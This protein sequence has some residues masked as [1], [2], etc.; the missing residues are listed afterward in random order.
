MKKIQWD[1][2]GK[3]YLPVEELQMAYRDVYALWINPF[4]EEKKLILIEKRGRN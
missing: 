3:E 4:T 2:I 1:Y